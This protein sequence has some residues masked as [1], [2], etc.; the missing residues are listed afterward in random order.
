MLLGG[1]AAALGTELGRHL[2]PA[3]RRQFFTFCALGCGAGALLVGLAPSAGA[4]AG[5]ALVQCV[6]NIWVLHSERWLNDAIPSDQRATLISVDSM[7]YSVL[8]ILASP[9]IGALGD[10]TGHA[11]V[12]LALLGAVV[13]ASGLLVSCK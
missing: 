2:R 12:G 1:I 13:A 3:H 11:G 7:A 9:A 5:C 8:M 10:L 6:I 4:L